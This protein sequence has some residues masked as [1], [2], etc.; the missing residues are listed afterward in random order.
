[1]YIFKVVKNNN[2][3]HENLLEIYP[4]MPKTRKSSDTLSKYY[5]K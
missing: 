1:M 3:L 2:K 5:S 4:L